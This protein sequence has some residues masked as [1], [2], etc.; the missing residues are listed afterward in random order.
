MATDKHDSKHEEQEPSF[1]VSKRGFMSWVITLDHKRLGMMYLVGTM[2]FFLVGGI[3]ALTL[4]TELLT[5]EQDLVSATTFNKLFTVHGAVMVFLVIIPSVPAALGN[6]LL[7]LM[8]GAKDVAFPRLNL[9]SF[10][11]YCLGS[12][13]FFYTLLAGS[14]DTGWTF[15][16]PY[17]THTGTA[18]IS[19]TFGAFILGFSSILTGINFLVT[20]HKMRAPGMTWNRLPLFVWAIYATAVIQILATPV[21][22]ITLLLLIIERTLNIGIFDPAMGGDPVLYQHF[23]WFYSH[24]AVYIMI[25]PGFGIISELIAVHSRKHI[26]GYKAI[27]LSSVAIAIISFIVW[28]HHMFVSGQ[29]ELAGIVFSF[30]TFAVAVPTAIKV[31][32]WVATLYKG[33]IAFNTPM[34]YALAFLFTFTI[35]GLTGIFL[36]AL[37]VDVHLHDTYFVVAHFHYV[38]MGGTIIAFIGGLHHWWPK[39]TGKMY[40]EAMGRVGCLIVF[41]GFNMTF[42]NQ[43]IIGQQ[44]MP[45][46][47]ATYVPQFQL[48]HVLSTIG[49]YMIGT[50]LL[51]TLFYLLRSLKTGAQ[52]P[53]DP[54]GAASLEWTIQSPP[55][56]H[57]FHGQPRVDGSPYDFKEIDR[58]GGMDAH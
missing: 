29:S 1:Y 41:I 22:A 18:V 52:A 2:M 34:L 51:F 7:P 49:A 32:S 45:R 47:Y 3:A 44:G 33:S 39:L 43:F 4:R 17:S 35:G 12:L 46:R 15:Y 23:F 21:L 40:N 37:S 26:F 27:A 53:A 48:Q 38:M 19:A 31:F 57:N 16:T 54:W 24:P 20:V 13:F 9:L 30:L 56:E 42:F 28:G 58:T 11:I 10:W 50:G 55:I 5:P 14:L 8:L 36:G 25:L 6:F